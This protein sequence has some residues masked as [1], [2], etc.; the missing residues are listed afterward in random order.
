M[1]TKTFINTR[2]NFEAYFPLLD[3]RCRKCGECVK[4]AKLDRF[5]RFILPHYYGCYGGGGVVR[6]CF[7]WR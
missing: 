1:R 7:E 3:L 6:E 5:H 2:D 4:E